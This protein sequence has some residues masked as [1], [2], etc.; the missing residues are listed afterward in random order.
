M[1]LVDGKTL[2]ELLAAGAL[3]VQAAAP[4]RHP[5]RRGPGQGARGRDRA[6]GPEARERHG[7]QGRA[8]QDPGLRPGQ[9]DARPESGSGEG[10]QL[11]TMTGTTPGVVVGTVGYMS[12]EQASGEALDFRSDQFSFGSMLYEMATGKARLPEEDRHR[13]AR[14]DPERRSPSRSRSST[15]RLP[16]PLR[17]IVERCLAKEPAAALR[18]DGGPRARSRLPSRSSL[19][20]RHVGSDRGTRSSISKGARADARHRRGFSRP[21]SWPAGASGSRLLRWPRPSSR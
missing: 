17:W 21:E 5:D 20:G 9:A 13:H 6:S 12:P 3:P 2:R 7:Q 11:P 8:R 18:L 15:R 16:A 10:S 4:A 1:E 14:G 19:R